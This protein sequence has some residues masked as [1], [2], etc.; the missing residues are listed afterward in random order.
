MCPYFMREKIDVLPIITTCRSG[1]SGA[2]LKIGPS[3]L[4]SM[5][6]GVLVTDAAIFSQGYRLLTHM[7]ATRHAALPIEKLVS[8]RLQLFV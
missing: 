1:T 3:L 8:Y 4:Y 5:I 6:N 2:H 7:V